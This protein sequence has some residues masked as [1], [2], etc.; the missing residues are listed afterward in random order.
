MLMTPDLAQELGHVSA[1]VPGQSFS[2]QPVV[3]PNRRIELVNVIFVCKNKCSVCRWLVQAVR[4]NAGGA[5]QLALNKG[6]VCM[7]NLLP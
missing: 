7:G 4:E 3:V 6:P 2:F 5:R 1:A